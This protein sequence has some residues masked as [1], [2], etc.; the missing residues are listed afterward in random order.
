MNY[1]V[2]LAYSIH[3]VSFISNSRLLVL[4]LKITF[5][6]T[7]TQMLHKKATERIA[8]VILIMML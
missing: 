6:L 2:D 8:K 1:D 5:T 4:L 7:P 3:W